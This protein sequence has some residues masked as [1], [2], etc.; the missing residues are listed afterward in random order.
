MI[1][2]IILFSLSIIYLID[3]LQN[4]EQSTK[5]YSAKK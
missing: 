1:C 4:M 5:Q 2:K 3:I